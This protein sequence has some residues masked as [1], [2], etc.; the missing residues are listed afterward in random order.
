M[1]W[2]FLIIFFY[3]SLSIAEDFNLG[4]LF[5]S[6]QERTE[7]D[8][9]RLQAE[10][11]K[12]SQNKE[13]ALPI[14]SFVNLK[15]F[16]TNNQGKNIV[17]LDDNHPIEELNIPGLR[18]D[19]QHVNENGLPIQIIN[20]DKQL[21]LKPGQHLDTTNGQVIENYYEPPPPQNDIEQKKPPQ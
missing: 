3:Y 9:L 8:R 6:P 16:M 2:F 7:L 21:K 10:Q 19:I 17:W 20:G 1:K 12:Y 15:G 5:F 4:R 18:L 11:A 13:T 14:P